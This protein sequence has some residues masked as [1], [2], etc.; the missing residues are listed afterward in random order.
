MRVWPGVALLLLSLLGLALPA[1]AASIG[2]TDAISVDLSEQLLTLAGTAAIFDSPRIQAALHD[3]VPLLQASGKALDPAGVLKLLKD[4]GFRVWKARP[5]LWIVQLASDG[6][7]T[8]LATE[9]HLQ[10]EASYRSLPLS[11]SPVVATDAAALASLLQR[12]DD[13]ALTALLGTHQA[14]ALVV[15]SAS[16][17]GYA[18]QLLHTGWQRSGQL[19]PAADMPGLL[20][21]VLSEVLAVPAEWPEGTGRTLVHVGGVSSFSEFT[22]L[23]KALQQIDGVQGLS[24]VR[25]GGSSAWFAVDAPTGSALVAALAG[26]DHLSVDAALPVLKPLVVQGRNVAAVLLSWTWNAAPGTDKPSPAP[27]TAA[28][29]EKQAH[30]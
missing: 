4:S 11:E 25:V 18:W 7:V 5:R 17:S 22:A 1:S 13:A 24:L 12:P 20:P 21:H 14:D 10:A 3:P 26:I 6:S 16:S 23:Q 27:V 8:L 29:L 15:V 2:E 9:P 30:G 28:P 19:P